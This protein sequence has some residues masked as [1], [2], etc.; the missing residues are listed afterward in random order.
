MNLQDTLQWEMRHCYFI[1]VTERLECQILLR[2][3]PLDFPL[4]F[5]TS[6]IWFQNH[7]SLKFVLCPQK[8]TCSFPSLFKVWFSQK[9]TDAFV[10]S[11][12]LTA[13]EDSLFRIYMQMSIGRQFQTQTY[14]IWP[15][16]TALPRGY[17]WFNPIIPPLKSIYQLWQKL[18]NDLMD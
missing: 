11:Q 7:F 14:W 18:C 16:R 6:L 13:A 5:I 15:G 1:S 10:T 8:F 9:N 2:L 17:M 4:L 3:G 12:T